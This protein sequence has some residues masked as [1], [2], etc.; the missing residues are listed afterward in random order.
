MAL[1][2]GVM[3]LF[4][5]EISVETKNSVLAQCTIIKE[6][7]MKANSW[8]VSLAA[9]VNFWTIMDRR[10]KGIGKMAKRMVKAPKL[11]PKELST[12]ATS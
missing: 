7:S 10:T 3:D 9:L 12:K 1:I 8:M 4:T 2:D 5:M 11:I 6:T